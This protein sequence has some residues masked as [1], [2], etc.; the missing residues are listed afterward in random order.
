MDIKGILKKL[1]LEE[2]CALASGVSFWDTTPIK[3]VGVP[4]ASMADGPHG[5]RKEIVEGDV[6]NV[7]K[8]SKEATC[9]PTAVTLASS[10]D[11]NLVADVANAIAKESMDQ[12]VTTVLGPGVNIK[13]NPLCGRNFEYFSEDPYL[14]G[15]LSASYVNAVQKNGVGTSLKHFAVNSQE[16]RR[17]VTSSEV[18]E[19]ALREIY[20]PAF[21]I[22]VKKAQPYTIM[23]SYNPINGVHASD[24]K[25]LLTDILRDEWGFNGIVISDWGAVNDRVK[26]ILAGMDLEMPT[27]NGVHDDDIALAVKEGKL[28]E[29]DL[30]KV[31]LRILEYVYKCASN[32]EKFKESKCDYEKHHKL[33]R[34]AASEGAV[35][36]KNAEGALPIK[37]NS[38]IAVVGS[39]AKQMRY[40][41]SGSS[42]INPYKLVSFTNYLD[43]LKLPYEYAQGYIPEGDGENKKLL[44]DAMQKA[45]G[46]D[47]VLAFIGL[48]DEYESEGFDRTH[49]DLPAGHNA[50]IEKLC[51]V[52]DNVIVVLSCGSPVKMPWL[53]KVKGVLN[54]YLT[55][56]AGGEACYDLVFGKKNPSGKLA[57]TFPLSLGDN[58][59]F[60]YYQMGP[61][62]VEYRESIFVGYRYY[63][64]AKK[65]VLFP[66]GYG[67][68]YTSFEY[69]DL[70]IDKKQISDKDKLK[71]TFS[72]KN[73]GNYDGAEVAQV[74]V[75]DVE[76]V[77]F[78]E[79]KSL[80][81]FVKVFLKK[82]QKKT[83]SIEL[84]KRA[85]AFYN[86]NKNDWTVENGKFEI[87][88]GASSDDI[89]LSDIVNVEGDKE[90]IP[91]YKDKAP[92]YYNI[93]SAS[94]ISD[95]QFEAILAR[96]LTENCPL[97]KGQIDM[98]STLDDVKITL[99]GRFVRW[100]AYKFS[101]M[102]LPKGSPLFLKKMVQMSAIVIPLR[103]MYAMTNGI[104]PR[105]T[106]NGLIM[107]FNGKF[108]RG[109]GKAI[110]AFIKR[111]KVKKADIYKE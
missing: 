50:L 53:D 106:V 45:K 59:A 3:R 15:E 73:K 63:D 44:E 89:R 11:I 13:R 70:E 4:S 16:Y 47:Y 1:T 107:A 86:V 35:L 30:D 17:M 42:R 58:P 84:D 14:A 65:D 38:N 34:K 10:W 20:L 66:F 36:L 88:V 12:N 110:K 7:M 103:N 99:F 69:G 101:P 37:E 109:L 57:E 18:D 98:N 105:E 8:K 9:F 5:L 78:R 24:N 91:N 48:T 93:G 61:Q 28:E 51:E 104:V 33:A 94:D 87:L 31:V 68:S 80:K 40:Q 55:G 52:N 67:L 62:T 26:G 102:A 32:R 82:G 92:V 27:S 83:V 77:I 21:E 71:I 108:F 76:S 46:K 22:T 43:E 95:K 54:M 64:T 19:R 72:I 97:K 29:K 85:F 56:Q 39:L 41:G 81:G 60:L 111:N 90:G 74:Y 79:E 96:P 2:K 100:A 23:C 6:A 49:L 25:K 75:K